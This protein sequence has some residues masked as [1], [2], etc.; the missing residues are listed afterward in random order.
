[1]RGKEEYRGVWDVVL[2]L[3]F[4]PEGDLVE[5]D[6]VFAVLVKEKPLWLNLK[7]EIL[8]NLKGK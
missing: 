6:A 5:D 7:S 3:D 8:N 2:V 1:M 4:A